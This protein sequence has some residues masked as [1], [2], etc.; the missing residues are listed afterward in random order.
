MSSHADDVVKLASGT[1]VEVELWQ[2]TLRDAGIECRVVGTELSAGLGSVLPASTELWVHRGDV[3][4]ATA[5]LRYAAEHAHDRPQALA[6]H[7]LPASDELPDRPHPPRK[8][9][10]P[11]PF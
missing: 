3:E 9:T 7:G 5:A 11:N 6:P 1:L 2:V 10:F 4:K 8:H